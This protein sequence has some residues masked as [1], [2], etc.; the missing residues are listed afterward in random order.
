MKATMSATKAVALLALSAVFP[1]QS[2][3][4][5][6]W[7]TP[8][9][10]AK[11]ETTASYGQTQAYLQRLAAAAPNTIQLTRFGVSPEGAT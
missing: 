11:F 10:Q 7:T 8:A 2:A 5:A 6:D 1:M 3:P 4:A 9:E